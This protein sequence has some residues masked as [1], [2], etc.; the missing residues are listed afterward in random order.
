MVPDVK[1]ARDVRG[2]S[3]CVLIVE[4]EAPSRRFLAMLLRERGIAAWTV[5]SAE[6]AIHRLE[7]GGQPLPSHVLV[8]VDLPGMSG[9]DLVRRLAETVP[10]VETVLVTAADP[11]L[12]ER[13]RTSYPVRYF[14]KPV[15]VPQ[16]LHVL[17]GLVKHQDI[18]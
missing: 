17:S 3:E 16:F 18:M 14:A 6:D 7:E 2:V 15:D 4:D 1:P 9:L 5:A 13:F 10:G 8:D 11:R 12:V